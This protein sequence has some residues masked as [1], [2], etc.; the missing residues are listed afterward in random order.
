MEDA[1]MAL[2]RVDILIALPVMDGLQRGRYGRVDR[3]GLL[4]VRV[5]KLT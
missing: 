5:T 1:T 4:D 3:R 2:V